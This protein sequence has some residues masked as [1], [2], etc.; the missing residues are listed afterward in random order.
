MRKKSKTF[1]RINGI[2]RYPNITVKILLYILIFKS[3]F[4]INKKITP[5]DSENSKV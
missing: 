4:L 3:F 2:T 1:F 5:K